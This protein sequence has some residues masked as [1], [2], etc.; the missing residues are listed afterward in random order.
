MK[1]ALTLSGGGAKG[2]FEAGAIQYLREK[3]FTFDCVAGVSV[4]S[5]NGALVA[6]DK[7]DELYQVWKTVTQD[8]VYL[9]PS[10]LKI[11]WNNVFGGKK[12]L[13]DLT[14]LTKLIAQ[15][16]KLSD[17]KHP[18]YLGTTS[19]Y[20]GQYHSLTLD[21]YANDQQL[22]D[23]VHA[24]SLM[25]IMWEPINVQTKTALLKNCVDGG[26]RHVTPL[27]DI[28]QE[29]P[30]RIVIIRCSNDH[31]DP[32]D[33]KNIIDVASRT[34]LDIMLNQVMISDY[35][36]LLKFNDLVLQAEKGGIKLVNPKN[37]KVYKYFETIYIVPP[38]PLGDAADFSRN[39]LDEYFQLGRDAAAKAIS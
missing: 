37:G 5:L 3:G 21:D 9:K 29:D 20:D 19:L 32:E 2:A 4:G 12:S 14:P 8:Q 6:Q 39:L 11:V 1:T 25:P 34:F 27:G 16:V 7:F 17:M 35:K 18:F 15:H 36:E 13:Y 38:H 10:W 24:S 31:L 26:V 33:Q 22:R 28:L 23:A 30:D